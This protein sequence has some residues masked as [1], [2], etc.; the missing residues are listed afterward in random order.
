MRALI[1]GHKGFIGYN[2]KNTLDAKMSRYIYG[3]D[4]ELFD[5]PN[6]KEDLESYI[7]KQQPDIILYPNF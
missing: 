1:T 5:S 6:W 2:L 3:L 7:Y 4:E